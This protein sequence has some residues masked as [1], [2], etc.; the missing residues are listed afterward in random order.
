MERS[1]LRAMPGLQPSPRGEGKST[2]APLTSATPPTCPRGPVSAVGLMDPA[3][4]GWGGLGPGAARVAVVH[5]PLSQCQRSG[6][7]S[8][9]TTPSSVGQG[10]P[11]SAPQPSDPGLPEEEGAVARSRPGS[12]GEPEL[13][14]HRQ[15][16]APQGERDEVTLPRRGLPG[17]AVTCQLL[18]RQLGPRLALGALAAIVREPPGYHP[19][20]SQAWVEPD[21]GWQR[22]P[23]PDPG[24]SQLGPRA[25]GHL[26]LGQGGGLG[27]GKGA[28]APQGWAAPES[29]GQLNP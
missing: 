27:S 17:R 9:T 29:E 25:W 12:A 13:A 21:A 6:V 26:R 22:A 2:R 3:A 4:G 23:E 7:S 18:A 28:S 14:P 10:T 1:S 15:P 5:Q 16:G 8:T 24:Q 20:R 19:A 11:R